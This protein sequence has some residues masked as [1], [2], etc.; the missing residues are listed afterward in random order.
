MRRNTLA[1]R[2]VAGAAL[3]CIVV[4]VATAIVLSSVFEDTVERGFRERLRTLLEAVVANTEIG[5]E[6]QLVLRRVPGEPRFEQP[7]SG[8]YWQVERNG[9]PVLRSRSLWDQALPDGPPRSG[10]GGLSRASLPGPGGNDLRVFAR[11]IM[12][13]EVDEPL[14]FRVAGDL[15]EV[16]DQV[17]RFERV[18]WWSLGTLA[19]VLVAGTFLQVHVGLLPLKRMQRVLSNIRLGRADRLEGQ[20]PGEIQPLV[21]ELNALLEHNAAVVDRARTHVG[22]LAHALKTPLSVLAN[23]V[24]TENG[25]LAETVRR[26]TLRMR[27]QV[28][29]YLIR[30]RAAATGGVL[31]AR[32]PVASVVND[33][34]RTLLRI[35]AD[36][37]VALDVSCRPDAQFRGERQDLEEMV[38]NLLDNAFKWASAQVRIRADVVDG[39]LILR[40]ED[41]GPGLSTEESERVMQRGARLDEHVPG[42]GLGLAIVRDIAGLYGGS[43]AL[44]ASPFGGLSANLTLPGTAGTSSPVA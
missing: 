16:D 2:L 11:Q 21:R 13:P 12:L 34:G 35:H 24:T 28:D 31:G 33:L 8:W 1:F 18:L 41:D 40:V 15:S 37:A 5:A 38:G 6:G 32:T 27:R 14:T 22:N 42:S 39:D 7:Y 29:H 43:I 9:V 10:Q 25:P 23:E 17:A 30:A 4:L 20:Y 26:Q 44:E 36:R 19:L 3:L